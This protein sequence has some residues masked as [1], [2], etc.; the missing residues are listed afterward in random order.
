MAE[1]QINFPKA[2]II[3]GFVYGIICIVLGMVLYRIG[4]IW[5][6]FGAFMIGISFYKQKAKYLTINDKEIRISH[7]FKK[8]QIQISE[9]ERLEKKIGDFIIFTSTNKYHIYKNSIDK[10]D[11]AQFEAYFEHLKTNIQKT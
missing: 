5:Y 11:M 3:F 1:F 10:N 8:K 4:P 9:I 6:L 2:Q 7:L